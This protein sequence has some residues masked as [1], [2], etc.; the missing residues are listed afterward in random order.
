[1]AV[2]PKD[3]VNDGFL[4]LNNSDKQLSKG[5]VLVIGPARSATSMV[6][7]AL[8]ELGCYCGDQAVAPI[9]EDVRMRNAIKDS[10]WSKVRRI[11]ESY[12]Q[13]HDNWF[14]KWTV[15]ARP[16]TISRRIKLKL[17]RQATELKTL[18]NLY[19]ALG[20][21]KVVVTFKDPF[22]IS[23]RNR[24]SISSDILD[25]IRGAI[26][27]FET[28]RL[29]LKIESP[30]ALLVSSDKALNKKSQLLEQLKDYCG[31]TPSDNQMQAALDFIEPDPWKYLVSTKSDLCVGYVEA[32]KG[33]S[34]KGWAKY[35][36][37]D[38]DANVVLFIGDKQVATTTANLY[39]KD[40]QQAGLRDGNCAFE[41][42][43]VDIHKMRAGSLVN[44]RVE[45]DSQD[46][47]NSPQ[48]VSKAS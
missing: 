4:R 2:P 7:G 40:L 5:P 36:E 38:K 20:K 27:A 46:L 31:L 1:M 17:Q 8:Y 35:K 28:I 37:G 3:L 14:F 11:A 33:N 30:R 13:L 34:V 43:D 47:S 24:L 42:N 21:P 10:N 12:S 23:N 44:V 48:I 9:Y 6:A 16:M 39:R 26:A 41:F 45:G 15:P 32:I 25:G 18:Q 22:S 19:E 29:F